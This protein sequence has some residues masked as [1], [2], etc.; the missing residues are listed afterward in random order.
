MYVGGVVYRLA[1]PMVEGGKGKARTAYDIPDESAIPIDIVS[2][3]GSLL[4]CGRT[5]AQS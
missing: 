2:T 1:P 3:A 4:L 5:A